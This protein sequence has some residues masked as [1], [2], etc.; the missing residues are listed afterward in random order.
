[1]SP[2]KVSWYVLKMD[3]MHFG[4]P[5]DAWDPC[6]KV[7]LRCVNYIIRP[8]EVELRILELT[9]VF[10]HL[11]SVGPK[12]LCELEHLGCTCEVGTS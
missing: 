1:M 8:E 10:Y 12:K 4:S 5:S 3:T 11:A 2:I 9:S 7:K 6:G